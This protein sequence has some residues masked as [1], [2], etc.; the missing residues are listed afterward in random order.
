MRRIPGSHAPNIKNS[1][2]KHLSVFTK[3]RPIVRCVSGEMLQ[4]WANAN[5]KGASA[6]IKR[7]A[8][9]HAKAKS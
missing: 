3:Y 6:E 8:D 7:R 4:Q 1:S 2:S 5:V 9:K